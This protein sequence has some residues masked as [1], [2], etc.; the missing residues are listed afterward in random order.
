MERVLYGEVVLIGGVFKDC[1]DF[2]RFYLENGDNLKVLVEI[3]CFFVVFRIELRV[4]IFKLD[5]W[6]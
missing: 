6:V 2:F 4:Q 1:C 5:S 3:R